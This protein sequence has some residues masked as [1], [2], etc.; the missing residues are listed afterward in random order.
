M[1]KTA[2]VL[3]GGGSRG[4]YEI[5]VWQ[6]LRELG[7]EIHIVTGTSVGAINGA[8]IAQDLLEQAQQLWLQLETAQ[9]F[10]VPI[11]RQVLDEKNMLLALGLFSKAAIEQGGV[12]TDALAALLRTY[13]SEQEV[14][15]SDIDLGIVTCQMDSMKPVYIWKDQMGEGKLHDYLL[16]SSSLFPAI[17]PHIID[18]MRYIDGGF[19]DNMPVGMAVERGATNIFAVN[20]KAIGMIHP[21]P[22]KR[23]VKI[24]EI[25]PYWNLGELL[26]F[27]PNRARQNMR[28]GYLDAMH[29]CGVYD[30]VAYTFIKGVF[31][32]L[33]RRYAGFYETFNKICGLKESGS[34]LEGAISLPLQKRVI[35]RMHSRACTVAGLAMDG[36]ESAGE[37]FGLDPT[38]IY[39]LGK[40]DD[41]LRAAVASTPDGNRTINLAKH[42]AAVIAGEKKPALIPVAAIYPTEFSAALYLVSAGIVE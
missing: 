38:L 21:M 1:Q 17:R 31:P 37:L 24:T 42:A 4:A 41:L 40:F 27:D 14:Y 2:L 39:S 29:A 23:G 13:I 25:T 30:G 20:V 9:L 33:A 7:E 18:G 3:A 10:N 36:A 16:A 28:L 15:A 8:V 11:D 6:A 35:Q 34:L 19:A 26:L 22:V 5:G 12:G 32:R